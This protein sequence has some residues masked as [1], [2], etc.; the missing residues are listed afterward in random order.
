MRRT[1][2]ERVEQYRKEFSELLKDLIPQTVI[3]VLLVGWVR[4]YMPNLIIL[5]ECRL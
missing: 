1:N 5:F 2:K 3:K 4:G